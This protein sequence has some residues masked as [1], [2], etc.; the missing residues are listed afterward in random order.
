MKW[1]FVMKCANYKDIYIQ[2]ERS[3]KIDHMHDQFNEDKI[4]RIASLLAKIHSR[5]SNKARPNRTIQSNKL[6]H[7]LP[8][9]QSKQDTS[10][11]DQLS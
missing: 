3:L 6:L 4:N 9:P 11:K 7:N 2:Y 8:P 5:R 10:K 1:H